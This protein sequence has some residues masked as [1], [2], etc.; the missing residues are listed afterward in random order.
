MTVVRIFVVQGTVEQAAGFVFANFEEV[1]AILAIGCF[2]QEAGC[3][4]RY[5][6][7]FPPL[8]PLFEEEGNTG[9]CTLITK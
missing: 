4:V 1:I 5:L 2:T 9:M 8:A 3:I 6:I 7:Y